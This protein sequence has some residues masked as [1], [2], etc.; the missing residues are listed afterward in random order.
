MPRRLVEPRPRQINVF[1]KPGEAQRARPPAVTPFKDFG[2][3]LSLGVFRLG[4][5]TRFGN[6]AAVAATA[7]A[8]VVHP[9]A[10]A[11]RPLPDSH[12]LPRFLRDAATPRRILTR[13][14]S[15]VG[16]FLAAVALGARPLQDFV[17]VEDG[18]SPRLAERDA[19]LRHPVVDGAGLNPEQVSDLINGQELRLRCGLLN[20]RHNYLRPQPCWRARRPCNSWQKRG[21]S[22]GRAPTLQSRVLIPRR[23]RPT[24][25][26]RRCARAP[27]PRRARLRAAGRGRAA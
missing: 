5:C 2:A 23:A 19:P 25:P 3:Y 16:V 14:R 6:R 21:A 8:E 18:K 15:D 12:V 13:E 1:D 22:P 11:L 10:A 24:P 7:D 27:P 9:V 26:S 17:S 20:C 4:L